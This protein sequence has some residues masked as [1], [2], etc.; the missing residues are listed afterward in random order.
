MLSRIQSYIAD[1]LSRNNLKMSTTTGFFRNEAQIETLIQLKP[2]P[3]T[4]YVFGSSD[5]CEAYSLAIA[6]RL[7]NINLDLK[8]WGFEID[9]TCLERAKVALYDEAQIDYYKGNSVLAS[10][11]GRFFT[12]IEPNIFQVAGAI[13]QLCK[14][15]QGSVLDE[16]FISTLRSADIVLCQNVF[17]HMTEQQNYEGIR[18]LKRLL[19]EDGLLLI[20]GMRPAIRSKVTQKLG[21]V[22][23]T[24][25][26]ESIHNG[27]V[28]LRQGWDESHPW[29]RKYYLLEPF[30][31][32][33]DWASR[34]G[35][36]FRKCDATTEA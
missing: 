20:G 24:T 9:E 30:R 5:G 2:A 36:I 17:V 29:R 23:I 3:R 26:A 19:N 14:F 28:D 11:K 10:S 6:Y 33:P 25:Q 22:P 12:M 34:Y 8:I 35:T 7:K 1:I 18:N 31:P 13:T 27:W 15:I 21:L 4:V 16:A 32:L